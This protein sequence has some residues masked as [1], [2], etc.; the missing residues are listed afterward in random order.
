MKT[1]IK[2]N[3]IQNIYYL[4]LKFKIG[5]ISGEFCKKFFLFFYFGAHDGNLPACSHRC[6]M[7]FTNLL[8]LQVTEEEEMR[9]RRGRD[10]EERRK[11]E[12]REVEEMTKR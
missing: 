7:L 10:E 6:F 8:L 2:C 1:K 9:K 5:I 12:G 11:R 3:N 4:V